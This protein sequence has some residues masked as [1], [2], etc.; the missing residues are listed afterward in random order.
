MSWVINYVDP[1]GRKN[2]IEK[3]EEAEAREKRQELIKEGIDC[4]PG[5]RHVPDRE[6]RE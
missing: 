3:K 6:V 4:G 1:E 2:R 5:L